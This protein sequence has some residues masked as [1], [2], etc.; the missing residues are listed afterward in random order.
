METLR[1]TRLLDEQAGSDVPREE[2]LSLA[3]SLD[4]PAQPDA[5]PSL[6]RRASVRGKQRI[7][8]EGTGSV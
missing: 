4:E 6:V 5:G 8:N 7:V 2:V 3:N 1:H